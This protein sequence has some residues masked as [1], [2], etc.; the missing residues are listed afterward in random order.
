MSE[1]RVIACPPSGTGG[2]RVG[3]EDRMLGAAC[4]VRDLGLTMCRQIAG[5]AGRDELDVAASGRIEW[6]AGE[7]EVGRR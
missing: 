2:R 1:R 7:P 5:L 3:I 4:R 6:H